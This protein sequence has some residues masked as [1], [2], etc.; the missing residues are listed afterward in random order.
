MTVPSSLVVMW[1][2]PSLSKRENASLHDSPQLFSGDVAIS[3]FVGEGECFLAWQS[4]ALWWWCG[5]L[6]LCRRGRML[7]CIQQ[8]VPQSLFPEGNINK[9]MTMN[10]CIKAV[11]PHHVQSWKCTRRLF[12][13]ILIL[14]LQTSCS[15]E[16]V[17]K[18][19]NPRRASFPE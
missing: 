15:A 2:S 13:R 6:H 10:I 11:I 4:P 8:F 17:A 12:Q 19:L 3:I 5:H 1:P 16:G 9:T 7:P 14:M 18:L